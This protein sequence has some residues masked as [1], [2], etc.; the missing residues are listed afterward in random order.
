[1]ESSFR[2][3]WTLGYGSN[4]VKASLRNINLTND[5]DRNDDGECGKVFQSTGESRI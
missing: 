1:M 4:T 2:A 5:D 3:T